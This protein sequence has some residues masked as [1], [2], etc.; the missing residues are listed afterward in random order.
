MATRADPF[1][2]GPACPRCGR[3]LGPAAL[4]SGLVRCVACG[5]SFEATAFDPPPPQYSVARLAEAGPGGATACAQHPGNAV[6]GHCE[7]CGV[8]MCG[9]CRIEADRMSLCPACFE[10]LSD[11]GALSSTRVVVRDHARFAQTLAICGLLLGVTGVVTGPAAI[12][13]GVRAYAHKK[14]LG[15]LEET[16][17]LWLVV[18]L[19]L[20]QL[21]LSL[22]FY[23]AILGR[24][25]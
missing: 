4:R 7:R 10:R 3:G 18:F 11:E 20:T 15:E 21:A 2:A 23:W 12:Y 13:Y 25:S 8:L 17:R 22:W 19:A 1:Y 9:M 5:G 14:A 16:W 24:S 6:V